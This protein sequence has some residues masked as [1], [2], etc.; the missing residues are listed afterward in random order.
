MAVIYCNSV[1]L[2]SFCGV[3]QYY[4]D[5]CCRMVVIYSNSMTLPSFCGIR[6]YYNSNYCGMTILFQVLPLFYS[7]RQCYRGN[8][9]MDWQ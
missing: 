5:N 9:H 2:P 3:R 6:K 1:V 4:A 8:N 7:M